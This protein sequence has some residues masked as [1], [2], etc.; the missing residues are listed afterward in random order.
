[1]NPAGEYSQ[2]LNRTTSANFAVVNGYTTA[3]LR[4]E[5][6]LEVT[7]SATDQLTTVTLENT[8][9]RSVTI[10]LYEANVTDPTLVSPTRDASTLGAAKTIVAKG[11]VVYTVT[12]VKRYLEVKC[13]SGGPANVRM[14]LSGQVR[15]QQVGFDKIKDASLY[16][17]SLWQA[18]IPSWV[19]LGN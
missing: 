11:R 10:Q 15:W 2:P 4:S 16:P 12:P 6:T 3:R 5:Q 7:T 14:L 17:S 8:G 9:D 1:M 19:G 18:N 13:T